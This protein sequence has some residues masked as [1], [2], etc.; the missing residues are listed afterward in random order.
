MLAG[1]AYAAVAFIWRR[2]P[3]LVLRLPTRKAA[4]AV[5]VVGALLYALIAGFSVPSQRT[6]YMLLVFALAI[7]SGLQLVISKLLAVALYILVLFDP[8]AVTA[9]G[10][11]LS[12]GAVAILAYALGACVRM[13]HWLPAA[14]HTQWAVTID[15]LPLLLLL[16]NQVS[17]ISP[18]ANAI[19]IPLISFVVTPLALLGCFLAVDTALK[20]SYQALNITML[21]LDWCNQLPMIVWQQHAVP[22]STFFPAILGVMWLFLPR[23]FPLRWLGLFGFIPVLFSRRCDSH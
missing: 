3:R 7:W 20:L 15:M 22:T 16:F 21:A 23:G 19:A 10:F 18:L 6:V 5:A 14:V 4:T 17:I 2:Q 9:P 8:W 13:P 11:W 12:F 1:M